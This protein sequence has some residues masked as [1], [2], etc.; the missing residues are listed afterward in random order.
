MHPQAADARNDG[1]GSH[2][3]SYFGVQNFDQS[4]GRSPVTQHRDQPVPEASGAPD[5]FL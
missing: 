3:Y 4:V 1:R 2:Q 5:D